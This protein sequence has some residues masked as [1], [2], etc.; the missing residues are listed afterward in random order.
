[1]VSLSV[2]DTANGAS[3]KVVTLFV[4]V[5]IMSSFKV[6]AYDVNVK[7]TEIAVV[8]ASPRKS[9]FIVTLFFY[10]IKFYG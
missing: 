3:F 10:S 1:M 9:D 4:E 6:W 5:T 7:A 2:T 8:I